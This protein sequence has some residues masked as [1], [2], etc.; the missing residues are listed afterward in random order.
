[1]TDCQPVFMPAGDD[2]ALVCDGDPDNPENE[3][4]NRLL[5]PVDGDAW[6]TFEVVQEALDQHREA[7]PRAV[8]RPVKTGKPKFSAGLG[9]GPGTKIT[10][11]PPSGA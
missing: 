5:S 8:V 11:A 7:H 4:W 1:M 10:S 9:M 2:L 6:V 3:A